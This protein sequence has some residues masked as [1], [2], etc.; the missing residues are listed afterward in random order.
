MS[1]LAT[2]TPPIAVQPEKAPAPAATGWPRLPDDVSNSSKRVLEPPERVSEVLFGL[3]MVLTYTCSI[4]VV[5]TG[6]LE[7]RHMLLGA[8]G[9]NVAWGIIDGVF[10]LMS[11]LSE[12]GHN[13]KTLRA[14]RHASD[15]QVVRRIIA[16]ELP[17][18]VVSLMRPEDFDSLHKKLDQLPEPPL[19]ARLIRDDWRGAAGV[20][21]LVFL[22]TFPPTVPFIFL[23]DLRLAL[24]LSNIIAISLLFLCGYS[25]ARYS[26]FRPWR[27]GLVM[28]IIGSAMVGICM[29][30]GG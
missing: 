21:L 26:G 7:V 10:Y 15:P 24:R 8:L 22:S 13:L 14:F 18:S 25:F 9:C 3:I 28:L 4:S 2:P 6:R 5:K 1:A 17:R 29:A 12:K 23:R 27:C 30:L 19:Y 20:M 11:C 16:D